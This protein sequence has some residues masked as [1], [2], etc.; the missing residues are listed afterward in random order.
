[1][2][3]LKVRNIYAYRIF[4]VIC[5]M[6]LYA[7]QNFAVEI[8]VKKFWHFLHMSITLIIF[9]VLCSQNIITV[10]TGKG[11]KHMIVFVMYVSLF[12]K[13]CVLIK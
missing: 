5:L 10:P 13:Y 3:L 6:Y 12:K 8:F 9:P 1:M 11:M 2:L 4:D 7:S